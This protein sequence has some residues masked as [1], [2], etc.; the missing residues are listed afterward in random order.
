MHVKDRRFE[1]KVQSNPKNV[2][3]FRGEQTWIRRPQ[4]REGDI[5]IGKGSK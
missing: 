1:N 4:G 2:T 5:K 3:K